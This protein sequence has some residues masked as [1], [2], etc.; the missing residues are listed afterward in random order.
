MIRDT[1]KNAA[2]FEKFIKVEEARYNKYSLTG[3]RKADKGNRDAAKKAFIFAA[4]M[5]KNKLVALYSA[6]AGLPEIKKAFDEWVDICGKLSDLP[7][8]D[9]LT[10]ASLCALLKPDENTAAIVNRFLYD[11]E[12]D[13]MLLEGFRNYLL[14]HGFTY[15]SSNVKYDD[16]AGLKNVL[17][18]PDKTA[19]AEKL[20]SYAGSEWYAMHSDSPWH[21]SHL[22]D[23]DTYFGYWCF[24]AAA[25][26]VALSLDTSELCKIEYIPKDML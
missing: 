5:Q 21:E 26:T 6:G 20:A 16:Y 22:S 23:A 1:R 4:G 19:Q 9:L 14:G 12:D 7:Y 13:D 8:S 25:L 2:Y 17:A 18:E 3:Y 11:F 10:M 15:K 24:E